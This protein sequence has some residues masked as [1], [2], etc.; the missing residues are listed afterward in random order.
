MHLLKAGYAHFV[1][2]FVICEDKVHL[3]LPD[4][5]HR[6][7]GTAKRSVTSKTLLAVGACGQST[8]D[9]RIR[10]DEDHAALLRS[11]VLKRLEPF[12]ALPRVECRVCPCEWVVLPA[13]RQ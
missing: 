2:K 10:L 11:G 5:T 13:Q 8:T 9:S 6:F 12:H 4:F 1:R 7:Q 3:P